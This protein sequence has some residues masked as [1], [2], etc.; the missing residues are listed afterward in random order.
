MLRRDMN[1]RTMRR[2]DPSQYKH[3]VLG[4][5]KWLRENNWRSYDPYDAG[6]SPIARL[7]SKRGWWVLQHVVR[8][9]PVNV[10]PL[11]CVKKQVHPKG[12]AH[13]MQMCIVLGDI[14][15]NDDM[16]HTARSLADMLVELAT[17]DKDKYAWNY[18]FPYITRVLSVRGSTNIV[19]TSFV[20]LAF[21]D[22]YKAFGK[23]AYLEAAVGAAE[24]IIRNIGYETHSSGRIC[25]YYAPKA[26]HTLTI[27]NANMVAASLLHR[28]GE[29]QNNK[30]YRG[31]SGSAAQYSVDHQRDD[32]LWHYSERAGW[33]S[34]D[35]LHSG[36]ILDALMSMGG[37]RRA[38]PYHRPLEKGMTG[39]RGFLNG[40]GKVSHVLNRAYPKDTRSYAQFIRTASRWSAHEPEWLGLACIA[41][42]KVIE[43]MFSRR[44][45]CYYRRYRGMTIKTPFIRW[46]I[47]PMLLA[48]SDLVE[49]L[50]IPRRQNI[51]AMQVA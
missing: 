32:G 7:I 4:M 16:L 21:L 43:T 3:V 34:I 48:L 14:E 29:M 25:F 35:C 6:L 39:F 12:L 20:A 27:H 36:F 37:T 13:A 44:G 22:A 33:R 40:D 11:L 9:S 2:T 31:L 19:N 18:P 15:Q 49:R 42:D 47:G 51:L 41:A 38:S 5:L 50:S 45:Y 8:L 28:L 24:Y 46:S 23:A 17:R 30:E 1:R 26:P 10:R